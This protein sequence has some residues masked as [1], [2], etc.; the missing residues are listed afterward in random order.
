MECLLIRA[1]RPATITAPVITPLKRANVSEAFISKQMCAS[2]SPSPRPTLFV[3]AA[4]VPDR[5]NCD[6]LGRTVASIHCHHPG[7]SILV[8][9]NDSPEGNV[10][11]TLRVTPATN[12]HIVLQ[13]PSRAQLGSWAAAWEWLQGVPTGRAYQRFVLLQHSTLLIRP[14]PPPRPGCAATALCAVYSVVASLGC[15]LGP[16]P[17]VGQ[18][19]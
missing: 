2:V 16:A 17:C 18:A 9:D 5:K 12:V 1:P 8:V 10:N 6:L 13:R 14:L 7:E 19:G 15:A 11:H 4:H 3:I